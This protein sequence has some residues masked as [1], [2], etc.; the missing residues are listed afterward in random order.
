MDLYVRVQ[1]SE[2]ESNN[3]RKVKV[4]VAVGSTIAAI[5]VLLLVLYFVCR[6]RR[7]VTS[8]ES[9]VMR[10]QFKEEEKEDLEL[11]LFDLARIVSATDNFSISNKLGEGGFGPVY[12]GTLD[13]GQEI[14]GEEKLLIYEYMPNKSLDSFI[15]DQTRKKLLN[16]SKRYHIICEIARGL[17]YL[18]QDSRLRIIH[19]DLKA[20]NILLDNEMNS[21]ISDFGLA[22]ILG[23]DQNTDITHRVAGTYGY[24]APE[25]ALDGN[26]SI[27]S[28]VFSFGILLL[29]IITGKK[30]RGNYH[31][32]ESI[33]LIGYAWDLWIEGKLTELIDECLKDSCNYLAGGQDLYI[34]M[35]AS[36]LETEERRHKKLTVIVVTSVVPVTL[37]ILLVCYYTHKARRKTTE[38]SEGTDGGQADDLD[39][40]LID[41]SIIATATD[42]FSMSNKIGEGGFGPVYKGILHGQ[43][44]AVKRLSTLSGQGIIEFKNE[45]K[46]IAKLQHRNLVKLHGCCIQGQEKM[47]VYEYMPNSS[48]DSFIFDHTKDF[49]IAR[50]CGG[51]QTEGS[52]NRIIG[53]YG[54][55]AP[56]YVVHGLF[57][58]KSDVFSFGI[59][60]LEIICG[61][62]SKE[63]Y[64][65]GHTLIG[66]AWI[67]WKEGRASE[68]IDPNIEENSCISSQDLYVRMPASELE[69]EQ[70][71][72]K[73]LTVIVVI[74]IVPV[75]GVILLVYYYTHK[76]R[77]KT[78]EESE[79]TDGGQTGDLDLPLFDLS[80]I[81]T[82]TDNFSMSNKI[83][84][85][86]FGP[87]Y[88]GI[89]HG[90]EIAVKRLSTHSWQG[91]IEFKNE[92]KLIAKLQ[93][94]NLVKIHGYCIQ[95][96]EKMLIYEFMPNSS[97][98]SFIFDHAKD[99]GIAR[100]CGADQTE[101][102]TNR[103]IGTYGYM[104][105]EYVVHGLFSVKSDVFSFGILLL[106][107]ICGKKSKEFYHAGH[108]LIGHAWIS[109]KEGRALELID[110]NIEE[111]SCIASQAWILGKKAGH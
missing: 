83:G 14:A 85:G 63:S 59:L 28:D 65:T 86:G 30:N 8:K 40:P 74:S 58:V 104:A 81:A 71:R 29:E 37:V 101:G 98:D 49:G 13:G 34:R 90:Q 70:G 76:A 35:P 5:V 84:E 50:S 66:H 107:I 44:I 19:R 26:F 52:T 61:K 32:R 72:H 20:S 46:L 54:Y 97:L 68:L 1:A 12:K 42:N 33:N 25:Y 75:A 102:N 111:G 57:S 11:P 48:L 106:E 82:A 16:W 3:G 4:G 80:I 22:R 60:L 100:S 17:L 43:E 41:L 39:L 47:L 56:E 2:L 62:K 24:M 99:F 78:T 18:H 38:E 103:I 93:H 67:S 87:V 79:G 45:V 31:Q 10:E 21:K 27:K 108:T 55:M 15:F 53:T 51:D 69:A 64:H 109:W 105:P 77:R 9:V 73:K 92:V 94:R 96:Q 89:L 36:E 88:K 110:P 6:R 95:G 7:R 23:E 91:M